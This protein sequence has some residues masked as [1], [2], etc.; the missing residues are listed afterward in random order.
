MSWR[1]WIATILL[2]LLLLNLAYPPITSSASPTISQDQPPIPVPSNITHRLVIP[3]PGLAHAN[4]SVKVIVGGPPGYRVAVDS[5]YNGGIGEG[6][7]VIQASLKGDLSYTIII[8]TITNSSPNL[9]QLVVEG[10]RVNA[11]VTVKYG[12]HYAAYSAPLPGQV[13]I[14]PP[15]P[16][17]LLVG[18][19]NGKTSRVVVGGE[20]YI[21]HAGEVLSLCKPA[22]TTIIASNNSIVGV[23]YSFGQDWWATELLPLNMTST[24]LIG[25]SMLQSRRLVPESTVHALIVGGRGNYTVYRVDR[26]VTARPVEGKG[27]V[28]YAVYDKGVLAGVAPDYPKLASRYDSGGALVLGGR[29]F[30]NDNYIVSFTRGSKLMAAL[31]DTDDDGKYEVYSPG[32]GAGANYY[33][34]SNIAGMMIL[35]DSDAPLIMEGSRDPALY[36]ALF[37]KAGII[38]ASN[39]Y[40]T[41]S[42]EAWTLSLSKIDDS[43][44]A[45]ITVIPRSDYGG[46]TAGAIAVFTTGFQPVPGTGKKLI[47]TNDTLGSLKAHT[48][49][50]VEE[51]EGG[52][53]IA[54]MIVY[55]NGLGLATIYRS[56]P[57]LFNY[58]LTP[59]STLQATCK[60]ETIVP[61]TPSATLS[62]GPSYPIPTAMD[63]DLNDFAD[64]IYKAS[65]IHNTPPPTQAVSVSEIVI[66][67]TIGRGGEA[68]VP[69]PLAVTAGFLIILALYALYRI[70]KQ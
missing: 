64:L 68:T 47:P 16:G 37:P 29:G 35:S 60:G 7:P 1:I 2:A 28:Y 53:Y 33:D 45:S 57:P 42:G 40:S 49:I 32:D 50:S 55:Q 31:L 46:I 18:S 15:I 44:N 38:T 8:P 36:E 10:G 66:N 67:Q 25:F 48:N 6:E 24:P 59:P 34:S 43:I 13:L 23:L 39:L 65:I 17:T 12:A 4:G 51:A 30:F 22:N 41:L 56:T 3:I 14:A 5:D 21:I 11:I 58:S 69:I 63:L 27:V 61:G 9:L 19:Y 20:T 70:F 26:A 62:V 52:F 54:Y